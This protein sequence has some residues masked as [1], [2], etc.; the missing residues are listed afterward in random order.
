VR[1]VGVS[2]C[3]WAALLSR[4]AAAAPIVHLHLEQF[5]DTGSTYHASLDQ[6][7]SGNVAPQV[8]MSSDEQPASVRFVLFP[9]DSFVQV[10]QLTF[11]AG[12][13]PS[14]LAPGTYLNAEGGIFPANP[15]PP[16][17][18]INNGVTLGQFAI[19]QI[20]TQLGHD[21]I[22]DFVLSMQRFS[23][24]FEAHAVDPSQLSFRGT[25]FF[26]APEPQ[27]LWLALALA[28]GLPLLRSLRR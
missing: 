1:S 7:L 14:F 25:L 20:V 17:L 23:V 24:S 28:S 2:L 12:S 22:G 27:L 13:T 10:L 15:G 18:D 3:L 9:T 6:D 19:D 5:F 21:A 11:A 8:L 26:T 4:S 16:V